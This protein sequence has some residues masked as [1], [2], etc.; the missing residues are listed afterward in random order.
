MSTDGPSRAVCGI[1]YTPGGFFR[2]QN[3]VD[4]RDPAL[5]PCGVRGGIAT[6]PRGAR[7][8]GRRAALSS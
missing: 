8:V 4:W 1:V 3:A 5:V 2:R 6:V 7:T